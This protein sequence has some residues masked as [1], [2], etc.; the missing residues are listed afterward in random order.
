MEHEVQK[1]LKN[2]MLIL[3]IIGLIDLI[4]SLAMSYGTIN[5]IFS[6]VITLL[7]LL[8]FSFSKKC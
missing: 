7:S 2:D 5:I 6:F 3:L 1:L 4:G 8:G